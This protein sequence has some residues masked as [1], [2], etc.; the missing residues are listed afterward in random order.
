MREKESKRLR[1]ETDRQTDRETDKEDGTETGT[2]R[3]R[4][5]KREK[6]R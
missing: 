1:G 6:E 2:R 3:H 4:L 5:T